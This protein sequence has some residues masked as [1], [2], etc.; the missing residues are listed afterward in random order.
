MSFNADLVFHT[1][2]T[3]TLLY[4]SDSE[5]KEYMCAGQT[6]GDEPL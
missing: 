5:M 2:K 4:L 3:A 1:I 6:F